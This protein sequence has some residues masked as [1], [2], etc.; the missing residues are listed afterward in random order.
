MKTYPELHMELVDH[1]SRIAHKIYLEHGPQ[2]SDA[3]LSE[4][5]TLKTGLPSSG[6]RLKEIVLSGELFESRLALES[7]THINGVRLQK[8]NRAVF[9]VIEPVPTTIS[10][11]SFH[12]AVELEKALAVKSSESPLLGELLSEIELRTT[13]IS[14]LAIRLTSTPSLDSKTAWYRALKNTPSDLFK[15]TCDALVYVSQQSISGSTLRA[16]PVPH[17]GTK[18]LEKNRTLVKAIL[19]F[20]PREQA[21]P[22]ITRVCLTYA[23]P[24][25]L[26]EPEKRRFDSLVLGDYYAAPYQ[27]RCIL[28]AE[29]NES[30]D[31]FPPF[32]GLVTARGDGKSVLPIIHTLTSFF[33][34]VPLVYWGDI[35]EEGLAILSLVREN[36]PQVASMLMDIEA[37]QKYQYLG[38]SL[39]KD[40]EIGVLNRR[41]LYLTD[42]E[43]EALM[44]VTGTGSSAPRI[45][46][47]RI[48]LED[49]VAALTE[50]ISQ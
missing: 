10:V 40:A 36:Y 50:V 7:L 8:L 39:S 23:D 15:Q 19:G 3:L 47:E 38:T 2:A 24:E 20:D 37:W 44:A 14:D 25:Y 34:N 13:H 11:D 41:A 49:I 22:R 29:N 32:P 31:R 45:E 43:R 28:I 42:S 27:P 48:P 12:A 26:D 9:K 33:P 16:L 1:V 4:P 30:A 6:S 35:D 21:E 46:Q 17:F 18:W 5:I